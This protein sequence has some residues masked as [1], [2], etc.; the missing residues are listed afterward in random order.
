MKSFNQAMC[1]VAVIIVT[2]VVSLSSCKRVLAADRPTVTEVVRSNT[3][4]HW[5]VTNKG[6]N[7]IYPMAACGTLSQYVLQNVSDDA[8]AG[9]FDWKQM[10]DKKLSKI[11]LSSECDRLKNEMKSRGATNEA[12]QI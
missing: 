4:L 5:S 6:V 1:A 9:V 11:I 7:V 10:K 12:L 8:A 3:V 2:L